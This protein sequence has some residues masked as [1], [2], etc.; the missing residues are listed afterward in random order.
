MRSYLTAL[1]ALLTILLIG[2]TQDESTTREVTDNTSETK[3]LVTF[4][5]AANNSTATR[6]VAMSGSLNTDTQF[7]VYATKQRRNGDN[8]A[9]GS[10]PQVF[11]PNAVV[12]Y[13]QVPAYG[14]EHFQWV[15]KPATDYYWPQDN[16]FVNFYAVHPAAAPQISDIMAAKKV[17]F[18]SGN[19]LP[20]SYDL[21]YAKLERLH[22]DANNSFISINE[23][24]EDNRTVALTFNHLLAQVHFYGCLSQEFKDFGW[25]VEVGGITICNVNAAGTFD[26]DTEAITE[27][28]TPAYKDYT[29]AMNPTRPVLDALSVKQ[30]EEGKDIPLTSP[31]DVTM[32]MPQTRTAWVPASETQADTHDCYL[33]VQLRIKDSRG[34]Y[35]LGSA[36]SYATVYTPF[37]P[38]WTKGKIYKYTIEFGAG[39]D[40]QGK[41]V[42]QPAVISAAI[43]PWNET[44]VDGTIK[45]H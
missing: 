23:S 27:A 43:Q 35:P 2:C 14:A 9:D 39:Y 31:T 40:A 11:I 25:T 32:L 1:I 10:T 6:G 37:N 26:F 34:E 44:S 33:A 3:T 24:L 18:D 19:Q 22:R 29:L 16:Y 36:S 15:W 20:G 30:D 12:S 5:A 8:F 21:M 13:Q 17:V 42:I 45:R 38:T 28:A 41:A 7:R 4:L